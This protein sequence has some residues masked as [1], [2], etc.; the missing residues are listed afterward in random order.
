VA[1]CVG[2]FSELGKSL[3]NI[4]IELINDDELSKLVYY[5]DYDPLSQPSLIDPIGDLYFKRFDPDLFRPPT[6]EVVV[7]ICVYHSKI[8]TQANNPYFKYGNVSITIIYH[9]DLVAIEGNL[10]HYAI[11][12]RIDEILNGKDVSDSVSHDW[13]NSAIY[14]TVNEVHNSVTLNYTN[15]NL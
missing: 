8:T 9:R 15:W 5:T 3:Q 4:V 13:F 12:H 14:S 10:R 7:N 2:K 6:N 11:M 1:E